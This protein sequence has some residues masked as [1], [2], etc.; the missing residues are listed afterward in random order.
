M[1]SVGT[2]PAELAALITQLR[3]QLDEANES[4]TKQRA[5]WQEKENGLN[6]QVAEANAKVVE[7]Q[8][9]LAQNASDNAQKLNEQSAALEDMKTKTR[10]AEESRDL[11]AQKFEELYGPVEDGIRLGPQPY[12]TPDGNV[13]AS[14]QDARMHLLSM[15]AGVTKVQAKALIAKAKTLLPMIEK[16]LG[17]KT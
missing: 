3:T 6:A 15:E 16:L 9:T 10:E 4:L 1:E 5:A 11:L 17:E 8:R 14:L 7:M 13:H 2:N 12:I